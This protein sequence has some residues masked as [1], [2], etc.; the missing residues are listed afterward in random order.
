M[1][2]HDRDRYAHAG[3]GE[4]V[5]IALGGS[6]PQADAAI[7]VPGR[8]PIHGTFTID[9]GCVCAVQ[10]SSPFVDANKLLDAVPEAKTAGIG[11]G[12]GGM[13]HDLTAEIPELALGKVVITKPRAEFSRDTVGASADPES[14]GLIG[15]L[16][17]RDFVLVLDYRHKQLWLDPLR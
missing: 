15:S 16:I 4:R 5:P 11:A 13:T 8:A 1:K 9:T 17:F 12:A 3:T 6:T 2:L 7:T 14:A 10:M